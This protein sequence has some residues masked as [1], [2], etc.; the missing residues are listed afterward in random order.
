METI[1]LPMVGSWQVRVVS[2]RNYSIHGDA[3]VELGVTK[4]EWA[5]KG[6]LL[7]VP[8]HAMSGLEAGLDRLPME[9][10]VDFL[11]GQVTRVSRVEQKS[12]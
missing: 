10:K 5:G 4:D 7:K 11:M 6:F 12:Q 2:A 8:Q 9:M 1:T 3:Y